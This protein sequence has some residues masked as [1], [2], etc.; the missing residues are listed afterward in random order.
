MPVSDVASLRVEVQT[1]L[2]DMAKPRRSRLSVAARF[3]AGIALYLVATV[4]CLAL[5]WLLPGRGLD[6]IA[7]R[8]VVG[9]SVPGIGALL[10]QRRLR[11]GNAAAFATALLVGMMLI[12]LACLGGG[13]GIAVGFRLW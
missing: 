4:A 9:C 6:A 2:G 5:A 10:L 1:A 12:G 8:L 7:V 13:I 3:V 11:Q